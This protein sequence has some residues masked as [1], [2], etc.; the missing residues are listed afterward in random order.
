MPISQ[1]RRGGQPTLHP[2]SASEKGNCC[3]LVPSIL[4]C[5]KSPKFHLGPEKPPGLCPLCAP[6]A[7]VPAGG[8]GRVGSYFPEHF[9]P[10][11]LTWYKLGVTPPTER[12]R[13]GLGGSAAPHPRGLRLCLFSPETLELLAAPSL[14]LERVIY[15]ELPTAGLPGSRHR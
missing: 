11:I 10:V 9:G 3:F 4:S 13:S 7:G 5:S 1:L 15:Y 14:S 12:E 6:G 2:E 8:A